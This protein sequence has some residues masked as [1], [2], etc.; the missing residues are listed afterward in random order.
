MP[1]IPKDHKKYGLLPYCR[2]HGGEVFD[3]PSELLSEVNK[4][5]RPE[6]DLIPYGYESYEEYFDEV[7]RLS[8]KFKDNPDKYNLFVEFKK[9]MHEMNCKE[10]WSILRYIGETDDEVF[11][12]TNGKIY[13]WPTSKTNPVYSGVIDNEEFTSYWY[14]TDSDSWEILEDPTGMAYNT[15]YCDGE[16]SASS[17]KLQS[18]LEQ[19][20]KAVKCYEEHAKNV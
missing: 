15:I 11:G 19:M 1:Y 20:K 9:V 14:A 13:Y 10:D 12:I 5:L 2:E 6:D 7:D 4:L 3:Y 18:I 17:E 8:K 16:N